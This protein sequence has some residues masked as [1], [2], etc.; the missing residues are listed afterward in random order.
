MRKLEAQSWYLFLLTFIVLVA[1][2]GLR[3]PWPADEPRFMLAAKQMIESGEYWF[4]QRGNELYSDKPPFFMW[5]QALFFHLCGNWR[6]AFLLPSFIAAMASLYLVFDLSK[7]LY[8]EKIARYALAA[9][10]ISVQF[11]YQMKRAQIDPVLL[12]FT[13]MAAYGFL[14]HLLLG[15]NWPWYFTAWFFVGLGI[16]TKG[17]G[18]L[19]LFLLLSA[20]FLKR[21]NW[22][23]LSPQLV[24][25]PWWRAWLGPLVML[26]PIL[27]W[28]IPMT[29][30][31]YGGDDPQLRAYAN[32]LLFRQTGTRLLNAWHHHQPFWYFLEVIVTTWLPAALLLP[33]LILHWR[34][35]FIERNA[36]IFLPLIGALCI[37]LFFSL[38]AGKRDMYILPALPLFI[39]ASAPFFETILARKWP[40]RFMFAFIFLLSV[41]LIFAGAAALMQEPKFELKIEARYS[42]SHLQDNPWKIV[43]V[44]GSLMSLVIF[45]FRRNI[46]LA[47]LMSFS[48]LWT[49]YGFALTPIL[50]NSLSGRGIMLAVEQGLAVS[51]EL[52][53]LGWRE[54]HYL[55]AQRNVTV[56][57]FKRD[58]IAQRQDAAVWLQQA[59]HRYLL[60]D[61]RVVENCLNILAEERLFGVSN[62]RQWLLLQ[63]NDLK[64]NCEAPIKDATE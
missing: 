44:M 32:D 9:L 35:S 15:P 61:A 25:S 48:L 53:L 14:R 1:G 57:G 24:S 16:M 37:I 56:F 40:S 18:F 41:A 54:Q 58:Q 23:N 26:I 63:G 45:W 39:L 11:T 27:L 34:Q 33:W 49:I 50:N 38:S 5:L 10:L 7:R 3:D 17:V 21:T 42:L 43:L 51:D 46:A 55:Q 62:R 59:K 29:I 2:L 28:L 36:R 6:I 22:K 4:T 64:L 19:P 13:T 20:F 52:A 60:A 31:A 30:Q 47:A 12:A 8:D